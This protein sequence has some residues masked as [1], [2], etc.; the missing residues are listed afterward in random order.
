M[1]DEVDTKALIEWLQANKK[2][3]YLAP[4]DNLE[5]SIQNLE[6]LDIIIVP[7]RAFTQEGK[8]LGRGG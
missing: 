6:F 7:G 1:S 8:R 3:I 5:S 4:T 2:T